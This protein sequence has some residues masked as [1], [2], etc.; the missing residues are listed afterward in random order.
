MK[1]AKVLNPVILLD[2]IDKMSRD[3]HGDPAAALLEVLD[4]EQNKNFVDHFL[5]IGY[6]LSQVMFIATANMSDQIPYALYDRLEMI[7]LSGY[8]EQ[9]KCAI[10]NQFLIPKNLKEY[11]LTKQQFKLPSDMILYLINEYT[12]EAGVRQ[13]ERL[14]AKLMRKTIQRL[15]KKDSNKQYSMTKER[16]HEWLGMPPYKKTTLSEKKERIG[17]ATG[18]AWTEVGGDILEI[19]TSVLAGKGNVTLTGQLGEVMQESAQ[20]ALSYIRS[21][22]KDLG[23]KPTFHANKDIHLHMPEGATPKDGPSAG[24]TIGT[25]LVSSLTNNP[26]RPDLA[27]TGEVTLQGRVLSIGGL[28]EKIL[29]AKQ[30]G[31][32]TILVPHENFDDVEEIK[33][34]MTIDD[35][36]ISFVKNMDEVLVAALAKN[37]FTKGKKTAK[38]KPAKR[39][40][41]PKGKK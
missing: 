27:M 13:L 8:S 40:S 1:K 26:T 35:L 37:P 9:E 23:L 2:E 29:A 7:S 16:I 11:S 39:V 18:L 3:M 12:R 4:P 28:K 32:K 34:E 20:A 10:T 41:K 30:H 31:C 6:D 14:I 21:R 5:D 25:A 15:L 38:N 36:S 24:I 17:L 33:K 19:E 22:A